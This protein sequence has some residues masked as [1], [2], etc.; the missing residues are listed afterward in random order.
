[1]AD[2][3][4]KA[5]PRPRGILISKYFS[6]QEMFCIKNQVDER[7]SKIEGRE[8]TM[9]FLRSPF[10]LPP[11]LVG[12]CCRSWLVVI[13]EWMVDKAGWGIYYGP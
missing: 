9:K 2:F 8:I 3:K 4:Y 10:V 13:F 7:G 11:P 1:M 5:P 6:T 12:G